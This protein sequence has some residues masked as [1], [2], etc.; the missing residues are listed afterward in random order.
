MTTAKKAVLAVSAGLI[1]LGI[2][3]MGAG[4]ALG[5]FD[6]RV[7]SMTIDASRGIVQFGG[8]TIDNPEDYPLL[9][10]LA[11]VGTVECG[12]GDTAN[13]ADVTEPQS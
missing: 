12:S 13:T 2:V 3:L 8:Q 4:F 11:Y 1:A 9:G 5:G 6:P 7:F 10:N